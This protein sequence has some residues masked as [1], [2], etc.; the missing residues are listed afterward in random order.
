MF[1]YYCIVLQTVLE[2]IYNLLAR[3][4]CNFSHCSPISNLEEY[5]SLQLFP[6]CLSV[7]KKVAVRPDSLGLTPSPRFFLSAAEEAGAEPLHFDSEV[8]FAA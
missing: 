4:K 8:F 2:V 3:I 1:K 6:H 5:C 7:E